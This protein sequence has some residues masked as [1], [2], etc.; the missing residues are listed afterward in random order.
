MNV[1][2]REANIKDAAAVGAILRSVEWL[3]AS[4]WSE[5]ALEVAVERFLERCAAAP[6]S[7]VLIAEEDGEGLGFC[8]LHL[9]P[10]VRDKCEGYVS[11]LFVHANARGK[12]IGRRLLLAAE[13]EAK[14]KGCGRLL[15]YINR[16]RP[17]YQRGFYEKV[18]WKEQA[19]AALFFRE[20]DGVSHQ[21]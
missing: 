10:S 5:V 14:Q 7:L 20:V 18:G 19:T 15:L 9:Y 4:E 21:I 16:Q 1:V 17:A 13:R 3:W 8:A 11:H 2:V 6:D 12:R